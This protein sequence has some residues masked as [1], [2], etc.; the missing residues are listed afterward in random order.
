MNVASGWLS[1]A[2]SVA[3]INSSTG[4]LQGVTVG[5]SNITVSAGSFTSL[6]FIVTVT[7]VPSTSICGNNQVTTG[8]TITNAGTY[9][10]YF[11]SVY[12]VTGTSASGYTAATGAIFLPTGTQQLGALWD[13]VVTPATSGTAQAATA[14]C[15]GTYTVT[16]TTGPG[17]FVPVTMS[18]LSSPGTACHL[19]PSTAYWVGTITNSSPGPIPEG[20]WSCGSTTTG[21]CTGSLPSLGNGTYPYRFV[22]NVYGSYTAMTTSLGAATA[23]QPSS[24]VTLTTPAPTLTGGYLNTSPTNGVNTLLPGGT[25]QFIAFCSYSDSTVNQCF[26]TP[27]QYGNTVIS[28]SSSNMAVLTVGAAGGNNPGLA[29]GI[30]GGPANVIPVLTG[31]VL[32]NV[33]GIQVQTFLTHPVPG[34]AREYRR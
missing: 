27:D 12:C 7:A 8:L 28:W 17:A 10:N 6:A 18:Q 21:S 26:P 33:W 31:N 9:P 25:V 2:T 5:T 1:A 16:S 4:V 19:N 34:S 14:V 15:K 13:L 22:S 30:S 32:A 3:T 24:Y 23:F 29:L 20:F 11:N